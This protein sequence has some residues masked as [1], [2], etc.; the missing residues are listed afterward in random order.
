[1]TRVPWQ[2]KLCLIHS[3]H[4]KYDTSGG[5]VPRGFLKRPRG[6]AVCKLGLQMLTKCLCSCQLSFQCKTPLFDLF[7]KM[8]ANFTFAKPWLGTSA[9]KCHQVLV[10]TPKSMR[11]TCKLHPASN[12][13]QSSKEKGIS[14]S[15]KFLSRNFNT[16][17]HSSL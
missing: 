7:L 8:I 11:A 3:V 13:Q 4:Q 9:S 2:L 10:V 15:H 12:P 16:S 1:M 6:R 5:P 17:D 14:S